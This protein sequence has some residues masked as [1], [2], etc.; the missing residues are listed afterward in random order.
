MQHQNTAPRIPGCHPT[1]TTIAH[2]T[3]STCLCL[4][5]LIPHPAPLSSPSASLLNSDG[6]HPWEA[7]LVQFSMGRGRRLC[8]AGLLRAVGPG[9]VPEGTAFLLLPCGLPSHI[10]IPER[11][12]SGSDAPTRASPRA[13]S[14]CPDQAISLFT[15][16]LPSMHASRYYW[17]QFSGVDA[18]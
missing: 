17:P 2:A 10:H 15:V 18:H 6:C 9:S 4:F 1:D 12:S 14:R 8:G 16:T 3:K 11:R 5:T 7:L 13:S